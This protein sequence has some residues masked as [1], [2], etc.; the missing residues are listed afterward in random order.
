MSIRGK[1]AASAFLAKRGGRRAFSASA[2]EIAAVHHPRTE[3]ELQ[4]Q[5]VALLK[6]A[7]PPEAGFAFHVPNQGKRTMVGHMLHKAMGMLPGFPDLALV[8]YLPVERMT[9]GMVAAMGVI[10]LKKPGVADPRKLLT[11][12][13]IA[14]RAMCDLR[15]IPYLCANDAGQVM[16]WA[17][18][19]YHDFGH[20]F[21][22]VPA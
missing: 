14:F 21:R 13:Q 2:K 22:M 16:S 8:A 4:M 20:K 1:G 9:T 3:T 11:E 5:C 15:G 19:F 12:D 10:E 18:G 17:A 6:I 7:I